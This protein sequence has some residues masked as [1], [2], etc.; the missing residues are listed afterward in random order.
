M[1]DRRWAAVSP[2]AGAFPPQISSTGRWISDAQTRE[3]VDKPV[4][5]KWKKK[6]AHS[7][8]AP[9]LAG[10]DMGYSDR[11]KRNDVVGATWP[12]R[13]LRRCEVV[14]RMLR[15]PCKDLLGENVGAVSNGMVATGR[16]SQSEEGP[17]CGGR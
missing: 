5:Q 17:A 11:M 14:H 4:Q 7:A 10:V 16:E 6:T 15:W 13:D 2:C 3:S 8:C 12:Q 9:L 1:Y